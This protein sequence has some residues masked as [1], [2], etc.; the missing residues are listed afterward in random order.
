MLSTLKPTI[1]NFTIWAGADFRRA[2]LWELDEP[3]TPV[4]LAGHSAQMTLRTSPSGAA[5]L[6]LHSGAGGGLFLGPEL[7]HIWFAIARAT[8]LGLLGPNVDNNVIYEYTTLVMDPAGDVHEVAEGKITV[9]T[10]ITVWS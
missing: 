1:L 5:A 9:Q 8:S 7:G 2:F 4:N 6:T 10:R 3:P